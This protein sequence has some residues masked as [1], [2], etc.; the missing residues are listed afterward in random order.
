MT[1]RWD[2]RAKKPP[3]EFAYL[4]PVLSSLKNKLHNKVRKSNTRKCNTESMW[5]IH[6]INWQQSRY[7][8]DMYYLHHRIIKKVYK[9]CVSNKLVNTAF[10]VK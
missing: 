10:I 5:P 8:Y 2:P 4:A 1:N 6:Q 3:K 9:Y 7:V